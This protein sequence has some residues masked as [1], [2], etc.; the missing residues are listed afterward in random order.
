M[1]RSKTSLTL[2]MLSFYVLVKH[3]D[4]YRKQKNN[5]VSIVTLPGADILLDGPMQVVEENDAV[6]RH[7]N[8][9]E[10]CTLS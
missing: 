10:V 9:G 2:G 5:K 1:M 8:G 6:N 3:V 4:D 7:P